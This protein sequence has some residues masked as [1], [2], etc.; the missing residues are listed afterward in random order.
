MDYQCW[1]KS[2]GSTRYVLL[3]IMLPCYRSRLLR[4]PKHVRS[5]LRDDLHRDF[6]F[7]HYPYYLFN[8]RSDGRFSIRQNSRSCSWHICAVVDGRF[9]V[10]RCGNRDTLCVTETAAERKKMHTL[11]DLTF[12]HFRVD[13]CCRWRCHMS[14]EVSQ[15]SFRSTAAHCCLYASW[16]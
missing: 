7:V 10:Y 5:E 9:L 13:L 6:L 15:P 1:L 11:F 2:S 3:G 4:Y 12:R 16:Y 8:D 14:S